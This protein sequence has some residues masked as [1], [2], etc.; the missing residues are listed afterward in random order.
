MPRILHII[1]KEQANQ[2]LIVTLVVTTRIKDESLLI[3]AK[4]EGHIGT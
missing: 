2:T 1:S 4:Y 3:M